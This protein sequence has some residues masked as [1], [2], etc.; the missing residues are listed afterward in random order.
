MFSFL[1]LSSHHGRKRLTRLLLNPLNGLLVPLHVIQLVDEIIQLGVIGGVDDLQS[2]LTSLERERHQDI[3]G[4]EGVAAEETT[5]VGSGGE[6]GFQEVEV[7]FEVWFEVHVVHSA[8]DLVC[9]W[10]DEEG[11]S[12]AFK[13]CNDVRLVWL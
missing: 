6:L 8:N 3:S 13:D 1:L 2:F 5:T 11:N 7:G 10:A 4:G 9:D 12:V